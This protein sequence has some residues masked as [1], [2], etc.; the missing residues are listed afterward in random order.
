MYLT[1][2][3]RGVVLSTRDLFIINKS[4]LFSLVVYLTELFP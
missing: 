4:K 1:R 3:D 2:F